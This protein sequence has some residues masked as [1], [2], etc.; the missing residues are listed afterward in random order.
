VL[1]RTIGGGVAI[2][3][4]GWGAQAC[5]SLRGV[6]P[7]SSLRANGSRERAPDDRLREAIHLASRS[8]DCFALLAMTPGSWC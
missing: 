7:Y 6:Q 8:M 2:G 3:W 5:S 4:R 1:N